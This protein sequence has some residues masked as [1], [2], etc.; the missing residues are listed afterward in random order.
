MGIYK[1]HELDYATAI[2]TM[3]SSRYQGDRV[4]RHP[5]GTWDMVY[6]QQDAPQGQARDAYANVALH[7]C[8]RDQIPVGVLQEREVSGRPRMFEVLGLA[9]LAGWQSDYFILQSLDRAG[10]INGR[11]PVSALLAAAE[12]LEEDE[13]E[14]RPLPADDY[15]A[16]LRT[17]R[18]IIARRGQAVFRVALLDAYLGRCA[19]TG[20]DVPDVL[21]AA[22]LRPYRGPDSND[23]RNGL[24]L[25]A[26]IHTLLDLML[27]AFEPTS[28]LVVISSQLA[29]THYQQLSGVRVAEPRLARQRPAPE[30]LQH[31]WQNFTAQEAG[32]ARHGSGQ[33]QQDAGGRRPRRVKPAKVPLA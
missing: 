8:L 30:I 14:Q 11:V 23:L 33:V 26:D 12:A 25:R 15:D 6:H 31:V 19:V 20:C 29:G 5:D 13:D 21:E 4:I 9:L 16:R 10:G 24:L 28:R 17:V 18:Q 2:V 22:H 27:V 32:L 1:P 3:V 7:A